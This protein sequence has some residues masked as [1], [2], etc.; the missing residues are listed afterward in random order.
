[1]VKGVYAYDDAE[2][3]YVSLVAVAVAVCAA[4]LIGFGSHC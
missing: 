4:L 3:V 1:M 2:R